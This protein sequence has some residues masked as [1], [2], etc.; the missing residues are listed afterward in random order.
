[1]NTLKALFIFALLTSFVACKKDK[2]PVDI[3]TSKSWS[4]TRVDKN[5]GITPG[6]RGVTT[7][8]ASVRDCDQDDSYTFSKNGK[9]TINYAPNK[10]KDGDPATLVLDYSYN[11]DSKE[12]II[13]GE[14]FT[15]GSEKTEQLKYYGPLPKGTGYEYIVYL[16]E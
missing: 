8:Y 13:N 10:C 15:I 12:L 4:P 6:I 11:R 14:K 7:I 5:F 1:M 3:L 9:L 16:F 2:T